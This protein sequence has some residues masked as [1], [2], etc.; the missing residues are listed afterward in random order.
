[1]KLT[2]EI[3]RSEKTRNLCAR[4]V[5]RSAEGEVRGPNLLS[6]RRIR[7][8]ATARFEAL[9]LLYTKAEEIR[10]DV[11]ASPDL[12][13]PYQHVTRRQLAEEIAP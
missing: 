12:A 10:F 11:Q 3:T 13:P 5:Q 8:I 2:V 1:M 4:V 7:K 9:S 6:G